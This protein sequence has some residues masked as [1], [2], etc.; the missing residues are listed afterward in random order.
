[1]FKAINQL[2]V[3]DLLIGRDGRALEIVHELPEG[4]SHKY[5]F[6]RCSACGTVVGV[7]DALSL[8]TML[9][10]QN[11]AILALAEKMRVKVKLT[12]K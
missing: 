9:M 2:P 1:M 4:A 3:Y 12:V 6:I 8:S 5:S 11:R 10:E 7:A